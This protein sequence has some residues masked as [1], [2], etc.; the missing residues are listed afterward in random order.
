[1]KNKFIVFIVAILILNYSISP[2][3]SASTTGNMEMYYVIDDNGY[4]T[5]IVYLIK[6]DGVDYSHYIEIE[7]KGLKIPRWDGVKWVEGYIE[8]STNPVPILENTND[9]T[10]EDQ[11]NVI[12]ESLS[13]T[14]TSLFLDIGTSYDINID[15]YEED[16][17]CVWTSSNENIATVTKSG[18]V[19]GKKDG[20]ATKTCEITDTKK[21]VKTLTTGVVIGSSIEENY[22]ILTED[23]L[24]LE[25]GDTFDLNVENKM[26]KSKYKWKSSNKSI[27]KVNSSNGKLEALSVGDAIITCTIVSPSKITV[28]LKCDISIK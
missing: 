5:D 26:A 25:V 3:V 15:N 20:M 12:E 17:S 10:S 2:M 16:S 24:D 13:L 19:T 1:M 9:T 23:S 18:K 22:P 11:V 8:T 4:I 6:Q 7:P 27:I 14:A 28:V 21:Q